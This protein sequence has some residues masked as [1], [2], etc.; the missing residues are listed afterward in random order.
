MDVRQEKLTKWVA[1]ALNQTSV[2]LEMVS[3]DASFR[4]YFRVSVEGKTWVAMDAP[5]DK[6]DSSSFVAIAQYWLSQGVPVPEIHHYDLE[7][8]FLLLNDFGDEVL[9][10]SLFSQVSMAEHKSEIMAEPEAEPNPESGDYYYGLA[11]HILIEI[12]AICPD[13]NYTLPLYDAELLQREMALFPDWL[14]EKKLGLTLSA[15]ER[16]MLTQSFNLL[17]ESALAQ[18]QVPVHRDYHARNLMIL[19]DDSLGVIDFQDAV[20]GPVTYDLV[21]LLRDCYIVWPDEKV[22]QWCQQYYALLQAQCE[23]QG[24]LNYDG[25]Q[26]KA[27]FDL[28]GL[29]RHLKAA[30]IFARL[31]L[32]DGKH[33]YLDDIPRTVDYLARVSQALP[34]LKAFHSF[35][36]F[37]V[38]PM[39]AKKLLPNTVLRDGADA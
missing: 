27:W 36:V 6:E 17:A 11:M 10:V 33:G 16:N 35:L 21:S 2:S 39:I 30:G 1:K 23:E 5:P 31:S 9:L 22:E 3:G 26:F 7:L 8:G 15:S 38:Q 32:R 4:R 14:L 25:T 18:P 34:A 37:K 12:Q 13:E 28:M 20:F 19:K 29:Q 24:E